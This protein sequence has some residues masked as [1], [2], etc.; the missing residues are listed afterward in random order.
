[1][2][3]A[4]AQDSLGRQSEERG[5]VEEVGGTKTMPVGNVTEKTRHLNR[6]PPEA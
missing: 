2:L 4:N 3:P 6:A 5:N 1:M